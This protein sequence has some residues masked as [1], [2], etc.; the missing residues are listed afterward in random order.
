M[1]GSH[2]VFA[3]SQGSHFFVAYWSTSEKNYLI[4]MSSFVCVVFFFLL[5]KD[6]SNTII[7][8]CLGLYWLL[9]T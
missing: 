4:V 6:K 8:L 5:E 7:Q 3:F 1:W 9:F 2:P